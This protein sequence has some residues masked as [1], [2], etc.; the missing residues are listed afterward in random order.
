MDVIR[1]HEGRAFMNVGSALIKETPRVLYP[2]QPL[3]G[4]VKR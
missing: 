4:T 1:S 3:E 2:L